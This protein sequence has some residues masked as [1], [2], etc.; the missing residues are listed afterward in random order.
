VISVSLGT[1]GVVFTAL[2]EPAFDPGGAAHTFCHANRAWHAMGVMLSCGGA[3]KWFHDCLGGGRT[4][5]QIAAEAAE[6]AP[7]A[8]GLA[9]LPY[10]T[11]ERC[12]HNDPFATGA[13][14]GL[15]A[16]HTFG[17]LA[18]AVFEGVSF[19]LLDGFRLLEGL[20]ANG[21]EVRVTSGGAR[22]PFWVQMLADC[23]GVPVDSLASD[24]GPAYGAALLAGV[25]IGLWPDLATA[26]AATIRVRTSTPPSGLDYGPAYRRFRELYPAL[27]SWSQP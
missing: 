26:C 5:D 13:F 15:R 20:G 21:T 6:I 19:G 16:S 2:A 24:E 3:V 23:F 22:S 10:L 14:A 8:E 11:G 27:K 7:G 18:R 9:F 1:S 17:H 12:P 4:Y 25:G